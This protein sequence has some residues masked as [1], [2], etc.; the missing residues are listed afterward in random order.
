VHKR[1]YAAFYTTVTEKCTK[2]T[3]EIENVIFDIMAELCINASALCG[4]RWKCT[5]AFKRF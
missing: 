2:S 1:I 4:P 5:S 3:G